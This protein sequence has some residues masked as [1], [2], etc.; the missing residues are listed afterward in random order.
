LLTQKYF[1]EK[2]FNKTKIVEEFVDNLNKNPPQFDLKYF[3]AR[4]LFIQFKRKTLILFKLLLLQ[5]KVLFM[6]SP[7]EHLVKT[8]MTLVSLFPNLIEN[9]LNQCTLIDEKVNV[10]SELSLSESEDIVFSQNDENQL[11]FDRIKLKTLKLDD[12]EISST[13]SNDNQDNK[14]ND[15]LKTN[16]MK[17][18]TSITNKLSDTFNRLTTTTTATSNVAQNYSQDLTHL[19]QFQFPLPLFEKV[20]ILSF[21]SIKS[22]FWI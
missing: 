4:D 5:K 14:T 16:L 2:D 6:L 11:D 15:E 10:E 20:L 19:D 21:S 8:I 13:I 17:R 9:G 18:A 22:F 3:S 1:E 12:D 7:I